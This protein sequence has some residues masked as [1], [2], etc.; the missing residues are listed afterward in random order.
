MIQALRKRDTE[1]GQL[2]PGYGEKVDSTL[3]AGMRVAEL[4]TGGQGGGKNL[5]VREK[6]GTDLQRPR[7]VTKLM[8]FVENDPPVCRKSEKKAAGRAPFL[9]LSEGHS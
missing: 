3:T 6:V 7:R 8:D 9:S 1:G 4:A 5:Q 2:I